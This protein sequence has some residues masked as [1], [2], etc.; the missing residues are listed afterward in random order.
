[1]AAIFFVLSIKYPDIVTL[2][3]VYTFFF[4]KSACYNGSWSKWSKSNVLGNG[5]S[6]FANFSG[7]NDA[8]KNMLHEKWGCVKK[9]LGPLVKK[10][11]SSPGK[12]I[13]ETFYYSV[14]TTI[15]NIFVA[16]DDILSYILYL[17]LWH[18]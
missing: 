1:M 17:K 13:N 14:I 7:V 15:H 10:S 9:K 12:S 5:N 11:S 3:M 18:L 4:S 8:A 16:C 6:N 2:N